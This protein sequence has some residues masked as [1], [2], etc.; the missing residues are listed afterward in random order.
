METRGRLRASTGW[1]SDPEVGAD[2]VLSTAAG[3]P[4]GPVPREALDYPGRPRVP[5]VKEAGPR[6][7]MTHV[8]TESRG[9]RFKSEATW[10]WSQFTRYN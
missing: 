9:F 2:G 3:G 8:P 10:D 5:S 6:V 1:G 7:R 4:C